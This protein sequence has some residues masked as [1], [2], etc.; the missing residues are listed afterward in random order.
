MKKTLEKGVAAAI[1]CLVCIG[2]RAD[3]TGSYRESVA[4]QLRERIAAKISAFQF[5]TESNTQSC[6]DL[7]LEG[8]V[9]WAKITPLGIDISYTL[10]ISHYNP[11]FIV[12]VFPKIGSSPIKESHA[13]Y[14]GLGT[15]LSKNVLSVLEGEK[16]PES[17]ENEELFGGRMSDGASGKS[18]AMFSEVE[19]I[20]HPGNLLSLAA[21]ALSGRSSDISS[22]VRNVLV[23]LVKLPVETADGFSN[24]ASTLV[25][26]NSSVVPSTTGNLS[27]ETNQSELGD[28]SIWVDQIIVPQMLGDDFMK[29]LNLYGKTLELAESVESAAD[30]DFDAMASD[31]DEMLE[32]PMGAVANGVMES[33]EVAGLVQEYSDYANSTEPLL[34][35]IELSTDSIPDSEQLEEFEKVFESTNYTPEEIAE[36]REGVAKMSEAIESGGTFTGSDTFS[37]CPSDTVP[38]APYYQSSFNTLSWRFGLP[39]LA[40][41]RSY[42]IPYPGTELFVG[43]FDSASDWSL[44]GNI[45]PRQGWVSQSDE[46]KNR[47][48]AAFRAAHVVT[49]E[50]Q[51]HVYRYAEP[52]KEGFIRND[53]PSLTPTNVESGS[54]QMMYPTKMNQCGLMQSLPIETSGGIRDTKYTSDDGTYI[55]NLWRRYECAVRPLGAVKLYEI[56][57]HGIKLL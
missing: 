40:F 24:A 35:L 2:V 5:I 41:R 16:P 1:V 10:N 33:S 27:Q 32:D 44:W 39:E 48:V 20:G 46:V 14:S 42:A 11:D 34:S 36:L 28:V 21:M 29:A 13:L 23:D 49:R 6:F 43:Q 52:K 38:L 57:L 17:F 3:D 31:L 55:Y 45:Y 15:K 54:W 12:S 7:R 25:G 53:I 4:D 51:P 18:T 50:G 47:S 22:E 37:F 56:D 30:I 9:V 26:N 19:I 8:I